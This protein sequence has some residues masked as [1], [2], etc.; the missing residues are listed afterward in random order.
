MKYEIFFIIKM[1]QWIALY[2]NHFKYTSI[3]LGEV[4]G[5]DIQSILIYPF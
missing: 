4:L 1:L 2:I 3:I 5:K